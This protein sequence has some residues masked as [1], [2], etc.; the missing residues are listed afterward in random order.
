MNRKPDPYG[1]DA[2]PPYRIPLEGWWQRG[3]F[4]AD[5]VQLDLMVH[6]GR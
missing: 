1:R 5:H 4:V 2:T 3:A 6:N